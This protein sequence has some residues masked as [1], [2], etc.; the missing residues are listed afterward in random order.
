MKIEIIV[1]QVY[2]T[3]TTLLPRENIDYPGLDEDRYNRIL[4]P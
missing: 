3:T 2:S 4:D 1:K